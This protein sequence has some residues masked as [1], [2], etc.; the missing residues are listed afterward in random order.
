M[1]VNP[2]FIEEVKRITGINVAPPIVRL[3]IKSRNL[4]RIIA[5]LRPLTVDGVNI[6]I[7]CEDLHCRAC[8][9]R[10]VYKVILKSV[11]ASDV[12]SG[13]RHEIGIAEARAGGNLI[14]RTSW[15]GD[16]YRVEWIHC[17]A[18]ILPGGRV[19]CMGRVEVLCGGE[20][21]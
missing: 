3:P 11:R 10:G 6:W 2:G 19:K 5:R 4:R 1:T 15:T 17:D 7:L 14:W 13:L 20:E 16:M 12:L 18:E 21:G 9:A 8:I